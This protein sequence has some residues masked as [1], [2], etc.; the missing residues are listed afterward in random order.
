VTGGAVRGVVRL[1]RLVIT[2]LRSFLVTIITTIITTTTATTATI[3]A[4]TIPYLEKENLDTELRDFNLYI[5]GPERKTAP[6]LEG[7]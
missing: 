7:K 2:T 4:W 5:D 1:R 3:C 6:T